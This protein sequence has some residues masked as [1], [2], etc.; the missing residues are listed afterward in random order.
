MSANYHTNSAK[1]IMIKHLPLCLFAA[2]VC[3]SCDNDNNPMRV[4]MKDG[5]TIIVNSSPKFYPDEDKFVHAV[6][7]KF[8]CSYDFSQTE[9]VEYT[10]DTEGAVK[11]YN[12]FFIGRW[13]AAK[14]GDWI[15]SHG[16][17]PGKIYY[18]ATK[19]Y[20]KYVS[21]TPEGLQIVP[22]LGIASMGYCPDREPKTFRA[23]YNRDAQAY[24]LSTGVRYIGYDS[25]GN[26]L[27]YEVPSFVNDNKKDPTWKFLVMT[28]G[29][30]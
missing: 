6:S 25:E 13:E 15:R 9:E 28:D 8:P 24:V 12:Q 11:G 16:L 26:C 4:S 23:D 19:V 17:Q 3:C 10:E 20:T 1:F 22:K 7:F 14:F 27:Y 18:V 2:F 21:R 5:N 29:W 30:D